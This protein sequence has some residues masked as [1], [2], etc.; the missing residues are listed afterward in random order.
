MDQTFWTQV[1]DNDFALPDGHNLQALSRE[2]LDYLGSP[3]PELRGNTAYVIL[4][5]WIREKNLY[6]DAELDVMFDEM[7]SNLQKGIGE[8]G[9][10]SV[11]LRTFSLWIL[12]YILQRD[13]NVSF[14]SAEKFNALLDSVADYTQ[15]EQDFRGYVDDKGWAHAA[16]HIATLLGTMAQHPHATQSTDEQTLTLIAVQMTRLLDY[17]YQHAED[18]RLADTVNIILQQNRVDMVFLRGWIKKLESIMDLASAGM[19]FDIRVFNAYVNTRNFVRAVYFPMA[20]C[21][22]DKPPVWEELRPI[23]EGAIKEIGLC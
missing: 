4:E 3:D 11:F 7:V 13:M 9:T 6:S 15:N 14:L 5:Q 16:A 19:V 18:D 22:P 10:D 2:L 1:K 12:T 21:M 23:L 20:L 17:V 8:S